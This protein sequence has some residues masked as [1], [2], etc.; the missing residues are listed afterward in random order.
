MEHNLVGDQIEPGSFLHDRVL[1]FAAAVPA[2]AA[3]GLLL[4]LLG[5]L[6][7]C[8]HGCC[9]VRQVQHQVQRAFSALSV[10]LS[11]LPFLPFRLFG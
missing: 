6:L 5:L 4:L 7:L 8:C 11:S 3:R 9:V 2:A 10:C 1:R